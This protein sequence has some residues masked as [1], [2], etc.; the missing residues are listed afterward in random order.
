MYTIRKKEML[1][2]TIYSMDIDAPRVAR[3]AKA[4]QFVILRSHE[5][6][7]RIPLTVAGTCPEAGTVTVIFQVAGLST[8]LMASLEEGQTFTDLAGPLGKPSPLPEKGRVLCIGGGVGTA[9]VYPSIR[10]LHRRG[11]SVD[12]IIGARSSEFLILDREIA[13]ICDRLFITTD[14]GTRGRKGFV[15][16][17][18]R[19]LLS[20]GEKY[21]EVIVIGP[22]IMM[23]LVAAVT[24]EYRVHT[25][26]SLNPIMVD[27]TGMCG[28]C[29]V[30]VGGEVKYACV[31]GPDFDAHL[32]DF[33]E[34]MNR[35]C[36]YKDEE[37]E[38]RENH[39]C[40]GNCICH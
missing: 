23:K 40:G 34:L 18:L 14:D 35:Q 33:D 15:T 12:V 26:A 6:G 16:D 31:D 38:T 39:S 7:E 1:A 30:T 24:R 11:V 3:K 13:P 17:Q 25:T 27:G 5:E 9:V 32:I 22:V 36:V 28:S 19:D 4:G 8:Q 20:S 37:E 2:P 29:R 10:E 21:D